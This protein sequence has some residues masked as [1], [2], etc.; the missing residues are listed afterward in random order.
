MM[1]KKYIKISPEVL[2]KNIIDEYYE[3]VEFGLYKPM[4]YVLA[5]NLLGD[6]N[7]VINLSQNIKDLGFYTPY[8]G[9]IE[10][11]N[12]LNNFILSGNPDNYYEIIFYDTS[13]KFSKLKD[14]TQ[15]FIDWGDGNVDEVN[16]NEQN[17]KAHFYPIE[18]N[19]YTV[20][21]TQKNRWGEQVTSKKV[22]IP[23]D[24]SVSG[25]NTFSDN[26]PFLVT[27]FTKSKIS[28]LKLY[29]PIKYEELKQVYKN[30]E[31]YGQ[32]NTIND[33]YTGYTINNIDYYDYPNGQTLFIVE[34][35][36]LNEE[37]LSFSGLTKEEVLLGIVDSPE[38]QSDVFIDRGKLSG[39]ENL[40][41][42]GEI[43]NLGDLQNYGY[44]Y[45]KFNS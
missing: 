39:L 28:E 32:I 45:F 6:I 19:T 33:E 44:K 23:Y 14:G 29:G 20:T 1:D 40:Q 12:Q 30:G 42:L 10:Q 43:D 9:I 17:F 38:I 25:E 34:S 5:N 4:E 41:R 37:D 26:D 31:F 7:I 8:D 11:E 35:H 22:K 21:Y 16:I 2:E 13:P 27:G 3:S 15:Y 18:D 24:P 36:G